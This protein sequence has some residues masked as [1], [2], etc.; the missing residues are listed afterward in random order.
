MDLSGYG[1][2]TG[3]WNVV[4]TYGTGFGADYASY[5][6]K[7][8]DYTITSADYTVTF[9]CST[10]NIDATLPNPSGLGGK[11]IIV[12][13]LDDTEYYVRITPA[14]GTIEGASYYDLELQ[15]EFV[16]LISNGS[17]SWLVI[18]T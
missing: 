17:N 10:E 12:K 8:S 3:S 5:V 7:T 9:T 1:T 2:I 6:T 14:S 13:K 4:V 15:W 16:I 18:G 11:I